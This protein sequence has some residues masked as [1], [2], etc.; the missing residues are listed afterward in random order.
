MR[1]NEVK[2]HH[3]KQTLRSCAKVTPAG[4]S[5]PREPHA[6]WR[7]D[8]YP[9]STHTQ[10]KRPGAAWRAMPTCS[11]SATVVVHILA[12]SVSLSVAAAPGLLLGSL[13]VKGVL[14]Y[15]VNFLV[16]APWII[17]RQLPAAF[18]LYICNVDIIANIMGSADTGPLSIFSK[19]YLST[20]DDWLSGMPYNVVSWIS[21]VGIS[22]AV[23][24]VAT[25]RGPNLALAVAA[26][27]MAVTFITPSALIPL[28]LK[29]GGLIDD[30][31]PRRGSAHRNGAKYAYGFATGSALI[32]FEALVL[33][34]P[35]GPFA[36]RPHPFEQVCPAE[37]KPRGGFHR[38]ALWLCVS[39]ISLLFSATTLLSI[40]ALG[41]RVAEVQLLEAAALAGHTG[42][43]EGKGLGSGK[44]HRLHIQSNQ[45]STTAERDL[46]GVL[47]REDAGQV[48]VLSRH[49]L[50]N[51]SW[52]NKMLPSLTPLWG[53]IESAEGAELAARRAAF[54][55]LGLKCDTWIR[56]GSFPTAVSWGSVH[57]ASRRLDTFLADGCSSRG[58]G[59]PPTTS[60]IVR[61]TI[62]E[63]DAALLLGRFDEVKAAATV[64]L[65]LRRLERSAEQQHLNPRVHPSSR[66]VPSGAA[67][68]AAPPERSRSAWSGAAASAAP[69]RAKPPCSHRGRPSCS[70]GNATRQVRG[71]ASQPTNPA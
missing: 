13:A 6:C 40:D 60:A 27:M 41:D 34:H 26:F 44:R 55:R 51:S 65:A 59:Q 12:A 45:T 43:G 62:A 54:E 9:R 63:L 30:W 33:F 24:T 46:V 37:A 64:A 36:L 68:S 69:P 21:L 15:T 38:G 5:T 58:E 25:T 71:L 42:A 39:T 3:K 48:V 20:P 67:A 4:A 16:L 31:L 57:H 17:K 29:D 7:P 1:R 52:P 22:H 8:A 35:R 10:L 2:G 70:D 49:P 61:L 19:L 56:L 50:A 11:V 18:M 32:L 66:A 14:I 23:I 47:L 53:L 28:M